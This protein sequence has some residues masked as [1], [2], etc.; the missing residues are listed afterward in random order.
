VPCAAESRKRFD[1]DVHNCGK[2][3]PAGFVK[4]PE[5]RPFCPQSAV[6]HEN[7]AGLG[8]CGKS[9]IVN[10]SL[11]LVWRAHIAGIIDL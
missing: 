4:M 3:Q 9:A 5:F 7:P 6:N 2:N 8:F 10:K 11:L 1:G